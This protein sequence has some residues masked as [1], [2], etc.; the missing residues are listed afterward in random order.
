MVRDARVVVTFEGKVVIVMIVGVF[1][2]MIV[3]SPNMAVPV[4]LEPAGVS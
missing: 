1:V 2:R 4:T 3:L